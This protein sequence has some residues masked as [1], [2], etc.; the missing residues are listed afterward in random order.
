MPVTD[1]KIMVLVPGSELIH[2]TTS[3]P[4]FGLR[5]IR[6]KKAKANSDPSRRKRGYGRASDYTASTEF[7]SSKKLQLELTGK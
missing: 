3:E 6:M 4:I 1:C 5:R 7:S 2:Y